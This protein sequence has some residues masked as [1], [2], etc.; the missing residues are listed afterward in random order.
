MTA[1]PLRLIL[2]ALVVL[3]ACAT[4]RAQGDT[5]PAAAKQAATA[6]RHPLGLSFRHPRDR[7]VHESP[8]GLQILPRRSRPPRDRFAG[9]LAS[10][11]PPAVRRP[12]DAAVVRYL[13]AAV[14]RLAP[15]LRRIGKPV[16]T[17]LGAHRAATFRWRGRDAAG[18]AG[19]GSFTGILLGRTYVGVS[20]FGPPAWVEEQGPV[21]RG[22]L[23]T[24]EMKPPRID[25][26]YVGRWASDSY[27]SSGGHYRNRVNV[28][29]T[30]TM[31]LLAD[32][33]C[34]AGGQSAING[35]VRGASLTGLAKSLPEHGRWA[36]HEDR[37]YFMWDDGTTTGFRIYV[38]GRPGRREVLLTAANGAKQLWLER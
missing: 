29:S 15:Q 32:G 18:R 20:V 24:C 34:H 25:P 3:A 7:M 21:M 35:Q 5:P 10:S 12:D 22:I 17:K 30:R 6:Y 36:A 19:A 28:S 23:A 33:T 8:Y 9:V 11:T 2:V 13:D 38:Q 27:H 1:P 31:I 14:K 16:V 4:L 26:R 37:V